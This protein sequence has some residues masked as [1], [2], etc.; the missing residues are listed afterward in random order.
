MRATCVAL[1]QGPSLRLGFCCPDPSTLTLPHPPHSRAQ[2]NFI[3]RRLICAAFAVRERLGDPRAVPGFRCPILPDM[4][5]P[6]TPESSTIDKFQSSNVDKGLRRGLTGSALSK[7]PQS[8]SRGETI[9]GL[10]RFAHLLRPASLLAPLYGSDRFPS[11]RG[12][13]LP[14][15]Q[16]DRLVAG[17]DY[18][19]DWT[20]LLAEPRC[21]KPVVLVEIQ[22]GADSAIPACPTPPAL[23]AA[24]MACQSRRLRLL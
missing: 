19:S 7:P 11:R 21:T 10:P 6:K 8:V 15:F 4:P 17:Y 18:N 20:P 22:T 5:S 2:H 1:L 9:S 13:L 16:R 3:A 24:N 12:L 14:G 23:Y